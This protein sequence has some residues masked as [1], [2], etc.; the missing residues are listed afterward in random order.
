MVTSALNRAM[1]QIQKR[2]ESGDQH[3]LAS[4]F[5]DAGPLFDLLS[6]PDHQI[7]FGRRG[8]GKTHALLY[9][10]RKIAVGGDWVV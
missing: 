5:V 4:T 6:T 1:L 7:M 2:A 9:L 8:T 3:T 10:E